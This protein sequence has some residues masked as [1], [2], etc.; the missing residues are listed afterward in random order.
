MGCMVS[1]KVRNFMYDIFFVIKLKKQKS[2]I[3]KCTTFS[4]LEIFYKLHWNGNFDPKT[5]LDL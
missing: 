1:V 3:V 5:T 4:R 2:Y